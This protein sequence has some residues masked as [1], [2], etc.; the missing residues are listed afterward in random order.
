M[1]L[2]FLAPEH[3]IVFW[4]NILESIFYNLHVYQFTAITVSHI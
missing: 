3:V 4:E 2:M 1:S